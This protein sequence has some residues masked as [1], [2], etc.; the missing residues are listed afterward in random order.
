[1][2]L[3]LAIFSLVFVALSMYGV[4]LPQR[5]IRLVRGVMSGWLG[6]WIAVAVRV[7][8]AALLWLSAPVSHTPTIFKILAALISLETV[9]LPIIGV[10]RLKSFIDYVATWPQWAIRLPCILGIALGGFFLWS[11]SSAIGAA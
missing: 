10:P 9:T 8:L 2:A 3:A 6:L 1:M 11:I 4:L 5:L 7:M